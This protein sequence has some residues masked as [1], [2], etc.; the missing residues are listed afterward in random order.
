MLFLLTRICVCGRS[1]VRK[2]RAQHVDH[3]GAKVYKWFAEG[4]ISGG[5]KLS[6]ELSISTLLSMRIN[7]ET[8]AESH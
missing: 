4:F 6:G 3:M 7:G 8:E 1:D 5:K 2:V